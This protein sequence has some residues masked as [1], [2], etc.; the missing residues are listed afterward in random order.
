MYNNFSWKKATFDVSTIMARDE[1]SPEGIFN[2]KK[3]IVIKPEEQ[4]NNY[5]FIISGIEIKL[6]ENPLKYTAKPDAIEGGGIYCESNSLNIA[7]TATEKI[8]SNPLILGSDPLVYS[9]IGEEDFLTIVLQYIKSA[10]EGVYRLGE[11]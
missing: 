2:G 1:D 8:T 11:F 7:M 3:H 6:P 9:G 4:T 10:R 5:K